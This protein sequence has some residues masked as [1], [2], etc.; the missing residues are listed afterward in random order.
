MKEK[1][2]E[3][4]NITTQELV[5]SI[6]EFFEFNYEYICKKVLSPKMKS[7]I[8]EEYYNNGLKER[9]DITVEEK[10]F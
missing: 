2:T 4:K 7:E 10:L 9:I 3:Q 6:N 8:L 5:M 1:L